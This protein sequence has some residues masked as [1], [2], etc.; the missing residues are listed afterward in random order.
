MEL[1][2]TEVNSTYVRIIGCS[3]CY[4]HNVCIPVIKNIII[5]YPTTVITLCSG[6]NNHQKGHQPM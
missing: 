1:E 5:Q 2:G 4:M 3:A 6:E